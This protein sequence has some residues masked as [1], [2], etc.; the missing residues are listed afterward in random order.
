M[1]TAHV[2]R[3]RSERYGVTVPNLSDDTVAAA[4]RLEDAMADWN[5]PGEISGGY[6]YVT[7]R[8]TQ[9]EARQFAETLDRLTATT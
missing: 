2:G 7:V 5:L 6:G 4:Y 3:V 1:G 9:D 8:L